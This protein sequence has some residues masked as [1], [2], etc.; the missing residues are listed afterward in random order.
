MIATITT[1][2]ISKDN[3]FDFAK[4]ANDK[5]YKI[6]K[7]ND[8]TFTLK[9]FRVNMGNDDTLP[10]QAILCVN[11]KEFAECFNDGWGGATT[12]RVLNREK[13]WERFKKLDNKLKECTYENSNY[14]YSF[15]WD[16]E[17]IVNT[18]ADEMARIVK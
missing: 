13:N 16:I 17:T 9:K 5:L 18:L 2:E 10:F 14:D 15:N 3:V 12:I 1:I 7:F 11:G 8:E 4:M 6:I